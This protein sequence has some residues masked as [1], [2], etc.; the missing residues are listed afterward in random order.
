[1]YINVYQVKYLLTFYSHFVMTFHNIF[2]NNKF[3]D[4]P[5]IN[6]FVFD[7]H[8]QV[9]HTDHHRKLIRFLRTPTKNVL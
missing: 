4:V 6:Y 3:K 8:C 2:F 1:M 5:L 7:K 9:F